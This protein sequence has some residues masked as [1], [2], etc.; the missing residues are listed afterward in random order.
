[1]FTEFKRGKGPLYK[2]RV[3][4]LVGSIFIATCALW[5]AMFVWNVTEGTDPISQTIV[6]AVRITGLSN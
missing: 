3:N 1:M 6:A 2:Q 4:T 5:A